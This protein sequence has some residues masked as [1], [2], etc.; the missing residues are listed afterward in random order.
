MN[1]KGGIERGL[2]TRTHTHRGRLF[3]R[4]GCGGGNWGSHKHVSRIE[5][6]G[7]FSS[8]YRTEGAEEFGYKG[9]K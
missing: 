9:R 6:S 5:G 2:F 3:T 4:G 8:Q 7:V 1:R